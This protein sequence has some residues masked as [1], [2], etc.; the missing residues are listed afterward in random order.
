MNYILFLCFFQRIFILLHIYYKYF[1]RVFPILYDSYIFY[2]N[3]IL[4]YISCLY[5]TKNV[6]MYL[7]TERDQ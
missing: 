4:Y 1:H 7:K 6:D 3:L 5:Y 2:S